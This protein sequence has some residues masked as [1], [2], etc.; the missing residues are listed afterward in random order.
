MIHSPPS[1]MPL[2]GDG[3]LYSN[4]LSSY[5]D[6]LFRAEGFPQQVQRVDYSNYLP[7]NE[8]NHDWEEANH[9]VNET[10]LFIDQL[11]NA[12]DIHR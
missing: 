11:C 8:R 7:L 1:S 3:Y 12:A 10:V 5:E 2:N 6:E 4:K 9:M